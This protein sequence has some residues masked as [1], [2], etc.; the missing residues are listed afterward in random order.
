MH[1][2]N[3]N[4]KHKR[5]DIEKYDAVTILYANTSNGILA[6]F[7]TF[8]ALVVWFADAKGGLQS[9]QLKCLIAMVVVLSLR[10]IDLVYWKRMGKEDALLSVNLALSRFAIG[11]VT[12][13]MVWATYCVVYMEYMTQHEITAAI[14]IVSALT[15]GS[16]TTLS[17]NRLLSLCYVVIM[18]VPFSIGLLR[19]DIDYHHLLGVLGIL[20]TTII[21]ITTQKAAA[22]TLSAIQLKNQ[23]IDLL[24]QMETANGLVEAANINLEATVVRRT[25]E[26]FDLSNRDPLTNLL[27]RS[28][29][30]KSLE[31]MLN[32][33]AVKQV[34]NALMFIDLDK[35]KVVNDGLGHD[36]GDKVLVVISE[37]LSVFAKSEKHVC[38]WGGDEFVL[39]IENCD[40]IN[41]DIYGHSL[42]QLISKPIR[43]GELQVELGATVGIAM[44][45]DHSILGNELITFADMAMHI[46][47]QGKKSNVA[48]FDA[49]MRASQ[50]RELYLKSGLA[51]AIQ[52]DELTLV[53]QPVVNTFS[54]EV[55]FCE[56]LL[57]W[58]YNGEH[59]S[60]VEFIGIAESYGM[61]HQIGEWVINQA[62]EQI[63]GWVF[64]RSVAVS[65]NV[66]VAQLDKSNIIQIVQNAMRK[67]GLPAA[68]LHI[69]ITESV[70]ANDARHLIK[71]VKRLQQLGIKVSLDDFGTGFSSLAQLQALAADTVKIDKSFIDSI[72]NG[73]RAIIQATQY[74]AEELNYSVV[75]EGVETQA[76]A[77]VLSAIGVQSSQ[78]YLYAKPMPLNDLASWYAQHMKRYDIPKKHS[79]RFR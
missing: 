52:N 67:T 22:F 72:T 17:G 20:F 70:F 32:A 9:F 76:Q 61:I 6:T 50:L 39:I 27:N 7:I 19:S 3:Y 16:A 62:C 37:R 36:V 4:K 30:T 58:K 31:T 13:A 69:E 60:P 2:S 43:I 44:F 5:T 12:T 26:I 8:F 78:G 40:V 55:E 79:T 48:V 56:V 57:R 45:P 77:D 23:N 14:V 1:I 64:G 54:N 21:L 63:S 71:Q 59:I 49:N 46:A 29:F 28:A 65:I 10:I 34:S 66:S 35:F 53:Y 18:L 51:K 73:G 24:A 41:A 33:A 68:C 25:Q 42:I 38:R 11:N 74:M 15:G 75:A 47:K